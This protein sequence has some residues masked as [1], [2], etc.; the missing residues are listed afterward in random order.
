MRED[1]DYLNNSAGTF[2]VWI[3]RQ[4]CLLKKHENFW[5]RIQ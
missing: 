3:L 5:L 1:K 4:K 2:S